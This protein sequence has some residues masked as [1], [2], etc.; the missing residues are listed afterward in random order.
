VTNQSNALAISPAS[1]SALAAVKQDELGKLTQLVISSVMGP[2]GAVLNRTQAAQLALLSLTTTASPLNGE[3]YWTDTGPQFGVVFFERKANEFLQ[4]YSPG[5]DFHVSYRQAIPGVDAVFEPDKGD[6]AFV[7]Q[8]TRDDWDMEWQKTF[9][10]NLRLMME[11]GLKGK[12]AV[13]MAKELTGAKKF[14]EYV[15]VV[16]AREAF[17][18]EDYEWDEKTR[19]KIKTGERKPEMF[20]RIER[21]KKRARKGVIKHTFPRLNIPDPFEIL[22]KRAADQLVEIATKHVELPRPEP[23]ATE[24][25]LIAG[26]G[27]DPEPAQNVSRETSPAP[28]VTET[29]PMSP[30][31]AFGEKDSNGKL[32]AEYTTEQLAKHSEGI[33][34][35][36]GKEKDPEKITA[37][38]FKQAAIGTIL[39][40]RAN[41]PEA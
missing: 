9:A 32:Y 15:G 34:I 1:E 38:Q 8:L 13:D 40:Y 18:G 6:V 26:L 16:D 36:I 28:V 4:A 31:M 27:Y 2:K 22:S 7:A 21:A 14:A 5:I 19:Q 35:A 33:A 24:A 39:Q 3:L 11:A 10:D 30:D 29:Y 37:L 12:E 41:H 23:R 17:S 20:D 25:Q